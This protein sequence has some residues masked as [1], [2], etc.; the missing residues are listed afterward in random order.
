MGIGLEV[1]AARGVEDLDRAFSDIVRAGTD[2]VTVQSTNIFFIERHLLVK[3][4]AE[5]PSNAAFLERI[6]GFAR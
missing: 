3:K 1:V 6:G 2:A 5:Y 4:M